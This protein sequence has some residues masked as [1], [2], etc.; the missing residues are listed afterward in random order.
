MVRPVFV[1]VPH[2]LLA[3]IH[4]GGVNLRSHAAEPL[5]PV[6]G[7]GGCSARNSQRSKTCVRLVTGGFGR[8]LMPPSCPA[9]FHV[10]SHDRVEH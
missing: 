8:L 9:E 1:V 3:T 2:W 7:D 4:R 10:G 6:V 5:N